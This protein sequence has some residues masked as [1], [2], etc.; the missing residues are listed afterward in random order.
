MGDMGRREG[1]GGI[2]VFLNLCYPPYMN[3][4]FSLTLS[5][6]KM[7]IINRDNPNVTAHHFI[8][9]LRLGCALQLTPL[10]PVRNIQLSLIEVCVESSLN[11]CEID[12]SGLR[13][14]REPYL[15]ETTFINIHH[16]KNT[17]S[18]ADSS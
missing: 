1:R 5:V 15:P 16:E 13:S 18:E 7:N 10:S 8:F 2:S 14:T 17:S 3:L 11:V 4:K 6:D 9:D 12:M